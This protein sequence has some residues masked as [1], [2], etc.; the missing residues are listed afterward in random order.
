AE[1]GMSWFM[2]PM[3]ST[4]KPLP[5][6]RRKTRTRTI[7]LWPQYACEIR[8][9]RLFIDLT[10]FSPLTR[11]CATGY[12]G[13]APQCAAPSWKPRLSMH[14]RLISWLILFFISLCPARAAVYETAN[15]FT[16]A[17]DLDGDGRV[18]VVNV[19][20]A[21]GNFRIG[22]QLAPDQ[23]SWANARGSGIEHL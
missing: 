10:T 8:S 3:R 19:D 11:L 18:D 14:L 21:S 15:E 7:G 5:R 4:T 16:S 23:F 17:G 12:G 6:T 1:C 9:A 20:K 2:V 22:Y 13:Q